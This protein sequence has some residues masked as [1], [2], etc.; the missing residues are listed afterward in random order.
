M[1]K[2]S[3]LL[4]GGYE[5]VDHV[6]ASA[7]PIYQT[8]SYVFRDSDHAA[9][10]FAVKDVGYIYT[11]IGNP[12]VEILEKR[13]AMLHKGTASLCLSSGQAAITYT[14]LNLVPP[15][16]NF[17][18][19][20]FLYGGTYNLFKWTLGKFGI[21]ARF[22]DSRYPEELASKIDEKTRAVFLE[23]IGNPMN[24]VDDFQAIADVAHNAGIP[25][26]VD[27]TVMPYLF[28]PFDYG[29]D[30]VVYS[31]TKFITGNGTSIGG[32]I[33]EKGDF[34]WANGKFP[35]F[36]EPDPS[37]HG[38]SYWE[39]FGNHEN[40][41]IRGVAFTM[42]ARLQY[43]RDIGA[44][45]SPFNAFL[46]LLGLETLH[47]RM[48][49]HCDNALKVAKF[50]KE[51]PKVSWVNY[52]GLGDHPDHVRAKKYFNGYF[53]A[54][55]GFGIRGGYESAKK[56]VDS[57]KMILHLANIGDARSLVIHPASTTHQQLTS[58]E[59]KEA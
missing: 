28:N 47:L 54:I 44:C 43:L 14:I 57:L 4:H 34:N 16:Y 31:T 20:K 53:G 37:Y 52:P 18:S 24:N 9:S 42:K 8:T 21:E 5:R 7:V 13:L 38:L 27:N 2:E 59:R 46:V 15:G 11:R 6:R 35:W 39:A 58:E 3:I 29:A 12:T 55:I 56:F 32:C 19:S 30:I 41:V 33:V 1:R 22:V 51:H 48:P 50:L 25:L 10:L 23:T 49:R 17:V 40:A 45:M 26:I 36:V